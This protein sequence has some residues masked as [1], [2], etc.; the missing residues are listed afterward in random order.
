MRKVL[1]RLGMTSSVN[2]F[3]YI[4]Y[5]VGLVKA[6]RSLIGHVTTLLYPQIA[7]HFHVSAASV[8][9]AIRYAIGHCWER[10]NRA[11]LSSI[12]GRTLTERPYAREFIAM[13][14]DCEQDD[15]TIRHY[16][17]ERMRIVYGTDAQMP[18]DIK[19]EMPASF[20]LGR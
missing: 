8:E 13:L 2:G 7:C 11:L 6:D 15:E 19:A 5:A 12:A 18:Y 3:G 10:G 20:P 14:A 17:M 16:Q 9:R 4:E 1:Y